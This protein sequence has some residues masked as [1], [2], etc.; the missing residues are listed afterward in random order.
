MILFRILVITTAISA[1]FV[2]LSPQLAN[3]FDLNGA[4]ATSASQCT[5]VFTRKGRAK[6]VGFT[7]FPGIY[8]GGFIAEVDRVRG[9][10]ESC[11][12]K[13]RKDDGQT[14]NLVVAC[15]SGVM[16]S[17]VQFILKIVNDDTIIRQFPGIDGMEVEYHRCQI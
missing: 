14:V 7:S 17:K 9:K 4:W 13:S 6:Q 1:G 8:G 16:L 5:K 3:A 15:A 2:L 11:L 12:V 10:F